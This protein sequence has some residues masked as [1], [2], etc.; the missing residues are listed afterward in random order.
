MAGRGRCNQIGGSLITWIKRGGDARQTTHV[1][2]GTHNWADAIA[3]HKTFRWVP[4][5]RCKPACCG[6]HT[7][8]MWSMRPGP[9]IIID[10]CGSR[11]R[12]LVSRMDSVRTRWCGSRHPGANQVLLNDVPIW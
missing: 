5:R 1:Q 6:W 12:C 7:S 4:C 3:C 9:G 11:F 10:P 2:G 8:R